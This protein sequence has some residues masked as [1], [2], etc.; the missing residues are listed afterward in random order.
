[1]KRISL[2]ILLILIAVP[3]CKKKNDNK[4]SG[5][6]TIDNELFGSGPYYGYGFSVPTGEKLSTLS[7]PLNLI[8]LLADFDINYTITKMY[9]S[10][11]NYNNSFYRFAKYNDE[12]SAIQAFRNL[13]SFQNPQWTELGDSVQANQ[14]WLYRTSDERYAKIRVISTYSETRVNMPFPYA[15]CTFEWVFQPDGTQTFP[16]K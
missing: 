14:I 9:F 10:S 16:G 1:M 15:E 3:G 11:S 7:N 5:T 4:Y 13:T 8:T 12:S 2:V 6:V